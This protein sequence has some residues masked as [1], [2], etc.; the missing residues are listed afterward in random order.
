MKL[1]RSASSTA[2]HPS[3]VFASSSISN[4]ALEAALYDLAVEVAR[5]GFTGSRFQATLDLLQGAPPRINGIQPGGTL[6]TENVQAVLPL[7]GR[8]MQETTL[9]VQGPPGSG[10]TYSVAEVARDAVARGLRVGICSSSHV[11]ISN[12][13]DTIVGQYASGVEETMPS[14]VQ[15]GDGGIPDA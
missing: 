1:T 11:N 2:P 14:I 7:L 8:Q 12:V 10:K 6:P 4:A 13:L 15:R 9:V 5:E 3:A